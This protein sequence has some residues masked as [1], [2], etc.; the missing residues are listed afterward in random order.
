[1]T[2][3]PVVTAAQTFVNSASVPIAP[4][5]AA[6][7]PVV[8]TGTVTPVTATVRALQVLT[9]GPTIE[10]AWLPVD[11]LNGAFS[12]A[13]PPGAPVK[14][15]YVANPTT[16]NFTADAAVAGR[17]TLEAQSGSAVQTRA[18]D[19]NASVP[20]VIFTFP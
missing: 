7:A 3:V 18:V 17:Y 10:Y 6:S 11:A 8:V 14:T 16:L 4:P 5:T 9:G 1:M 19:I 15:N 13:L 2:G 12:A 20:P